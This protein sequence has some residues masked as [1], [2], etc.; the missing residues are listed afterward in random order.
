MELTFV[1]IGEMPSFVERI[2]LNEDL[3]NGYAINCEITL[4]QNELRLLEF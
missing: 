2:N 4:K 1:S 3:N